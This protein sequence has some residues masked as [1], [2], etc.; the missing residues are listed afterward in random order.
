ML[1]RDAP[2]EGPKA[3]IRVPTNREGRQRVHW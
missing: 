2:G 1:L 3:G